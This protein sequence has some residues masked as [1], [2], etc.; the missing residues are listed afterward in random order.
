[1]FIYTVME[2]TLNDSN[3]KEEVLNTKGLVLVDF[4]ASWCMPCLMLGPIIEEIAHENKDVKVGKINV[5]ENPTLS[6]EYS[7]MSI[8]AVKLFKDG[9]V[10]EEWVGVQPKAVY[11]RALEIH[12][13]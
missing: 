10:V 11:V 8:P 13:N 6:Q 9:K 3:F 5:D 12:S 7:I 2:I 4:W 1:M